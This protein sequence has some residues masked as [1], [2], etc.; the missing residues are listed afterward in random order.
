MTKT[1]E[2]K[3]PVLAIMRPE[4]YR[5]KSEA[6]AR[7]YGFEPFY[8]PMIRLEGLKDEGFEPFVQ[9]VI[10]GVSDYVIFTSA[11]GITFTL[12]KLSESEKES[13]VEALKK[14]R[15]IAIGPNTEKELVK[16]G[17]EKPFLPGDY[18]SEGIV[19]DLCPEVKGKTV[20]LARS[21]FGAKLL[22]E[23]LK[24]CGA[25]VYETHV[26]TLTI[27]EGKTQ[28]EL[29]ERSLA[30]EIAAF[31]FTSS[32]MI[33][34]FMKHAELAGAEEEIKEVLRKA[35]VGAI[36][37]PTAK[38]LENYGVSADAVPEEFTFEALLAVLK[39][40]L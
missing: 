27:P 37:T 23:G 14:T 25:T 38:T 18:S 21:E 13:F 31:A 29:I 3:M 36:G 40:K 39:S 33:R 9:R 7:A 6:L 26:Y 24:E 4:S 19:R 20:D 22:I 1:N 30:G 28:K 12:N 15:V 35:L 2:A 11:N 5:E 34:G 17:I 8:A 16:I 10:E 32:M